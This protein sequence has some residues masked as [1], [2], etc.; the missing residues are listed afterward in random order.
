M[1]QS[2]S[3]N[4]LSLVVR[5]NGAPNLS[6]TQTV[7]ISVSLPASPQISSP[8]INNGALQF[9]VTGNSGPDYL[10]EATTNLSLP[11]SWMTLSYLSSPA[12]PFCFTNN[13]L[14]NISQQYYRLQLGP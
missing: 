9:T 6:A 2:P 8:S 12:L 11:G 14:T 7:F 5:D 4:A 10:V 1:A 3:T 13:R